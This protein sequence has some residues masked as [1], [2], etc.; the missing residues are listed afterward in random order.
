M[1]PARRLLARQAWPSFLISLAQH[2]AVMTTAEGRARMPLPE[3]AQAERLK[4]YSLIVNVLDQLFRIP[5]TRWRF[6]LDPLFGLI[7]GAGDVATALLGSYGLV[8]AYQIGAPAA[9]HVRMLMNLLV[10]AALGAIPIAGDLFDFAFK[11]HVRNQR[12]LLEGLERPRQAR[13]SSVFVLAGALLALSA[14]V[15][16][17]VWLVV[18]AVSAVFRLLTG[19]A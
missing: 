3:V 17:A 19:P 10:D 1:A 16:G 4:R 2:E 7:P 14:T 18:L 15:V 9:I 6:G 13:R 12:L 5:G 8:V 11:A